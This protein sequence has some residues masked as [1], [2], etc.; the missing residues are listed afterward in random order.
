MLAEAEVPKSLS[1]FC[2]QTS[3]IAVRE[4]MFKM[5]LKWPLVKAISLPASHSVGRRIRPTL[6]IAG[7]VGLIQRCWMELDVMESSPRLPFTSGD[8]DAA[9]VLTEIF[10]KSRIKAHHWICNTPGS[11]NSMFEAS[12]PLRLLR[13]DLGEQRDPRVQARNLRMGARPLAIRGQCAAARTLSCS[14]DQPAGHD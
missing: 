6:L 9:L 5:L 11:F 7:S 4:N 13:S 8:Q 2:V 10:E 1:R 14:A 3:I 12:A